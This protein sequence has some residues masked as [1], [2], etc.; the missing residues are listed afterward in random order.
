M[1]DCSEKHNCKLGF[2][3][4]SLCVIEMRSYVML[5]KSEEGIMNYCMPCPN[6]EYLKMSSYNA[7]YVWNN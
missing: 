1:I 2:D 4:L 7:A 3:L 6:R 5:I